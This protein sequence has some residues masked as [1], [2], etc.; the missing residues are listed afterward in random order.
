MNV[1][2]ENKLWRRNLIMEFHE[3]GMNDK[4]IS[5]YLN[6]KKIK[7]IA[8]KKYYPKLVWAV[9]DKYKKRLLRSESKDLKIEDLHFII[10]Y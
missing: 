7:T 5:E 2:F 4:E 9:R 8:D 3:K 6:H 10:E 1:G